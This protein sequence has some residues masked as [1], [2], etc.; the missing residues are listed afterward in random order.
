MT[1][2]L[3][4]RNRAGNSLQMDFVSNSQ[5]QLKAIATT[6]VHTNTNI[7][8]AQEFLVE[9]EVELKVAPELLESLHVAA[10][11]AWGQLQLCMSKACIFLVDVFHKLPSIPY[12]TPSPT[13]DTSIKTA[14][15]VCARYFIANA[16]MPLSCGCLYHLVCLRDPILQG[17][18]GSIIT[19]LGCGI[20]VYGT[21]LASWGFSLHSSTV[22]KLEVE[23]D[24]MDN[25][26]DWVKA[27]WGQSKTAS[28]VPQ[29]HR[30]PVTHFD[31]LGISSNSTVLSSS[32]PPTE[33]GFGPDR[34]SSLND[35]DQYFIYL[36][37]WAQRIHG[38][39]LPVPQLE[40]SCA[41]TTQILCYNN[42]TPMPELSL[43]GDQWLK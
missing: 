29:V 25:A 42:T 41:T 36:D 12:D 4:I 18:T 37:T 14:C 32:S 40:D 19:C 8:G 1:S 11:I 43:Q 22:A 38:Y 7:E 24:V 35:V 5:L 21:W 28:S 9:Q 3:Q 30:R 2:F 15:L 39:S 20:L 13:S 33:D 6:I 31:D 26:N 16:I 17:S 27:P 23:L 34:C 10:K